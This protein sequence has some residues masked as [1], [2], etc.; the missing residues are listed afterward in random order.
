MAII[1][2]RCDHD[3]LN[4]YWKKVSMKRKN[5]RNIIIQKR[6]FMQSDLA[7]SVRYYQR[8]KGLL[9]TRSS[10]SMQQYSLTEG[11]R[12]THTHTHTHTPAA[13]GSSQARGRIR[14]VAPGLHHRGMGILIYK[15]CCN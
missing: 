11:T 6:D 10:G 12:I 13:C 7:V 14:A 1:L 3:Q 15:F 4:E 5:F 8:V 9:I 2:P